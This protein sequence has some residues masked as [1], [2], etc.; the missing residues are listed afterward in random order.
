MVTVFGGSTKELAGTLTMTELA[1]VP[2]TAE[3][4]DDGTFSQDTMTTEL[5]DD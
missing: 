4:T 1:T 3:G 2:I 5:D